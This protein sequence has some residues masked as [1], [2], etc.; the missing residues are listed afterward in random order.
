[1]ESD[2]MAEY[3]RGV[4]D[5]GTRA[6]SS[7]NDLPAVKRGAALRKPSLREFAGGGGPSSSSSSAENLLKDSRRGSST[8]A[9][10]E[11]DRAR[12]D[13]TVGGG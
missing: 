9:P 8:D 12:S 10:I 5:S 3:L 2:R 1:M 6:A 4:V 11:A 7:D 13:A